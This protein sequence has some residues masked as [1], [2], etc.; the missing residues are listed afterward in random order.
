VSS[1]VAIEAQPG[2]AAESPAPHQPVLDRRRAETVRTPEA[3]PDTGRGGE[4]DVETHEIHELERA[5]RESIGPQGGIDLTDPGFASLE[6]PQG[7]D[8]ERPID[9]IDDEAR[10]VRG[11]NRGL[12]PGRHDR[13]R[14]LEDRG[15]GASAGD[16]LDEPPN[17][18][19]MGMPRRHGRRGTSID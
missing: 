5:H 10:G 16:D 18:A 8:G 9:S 17:A 19:W 2:L 3:F 11:A 13:C 15:F 4:I 1:V 14:S 6:H 12:A 7:L